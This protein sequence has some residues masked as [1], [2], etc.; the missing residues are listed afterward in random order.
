[1]LNTNWTQHRTDFQKFLPHLGRTF[2]WNALTSTTRSRRCYLWRYEMRQKRFV[3]TEAALQH[4]M[5]S[6]MKFKHGLVWD[7]LSNCNRALP[8]ASFRT[9]TDCCAV[10][11]H[12]GQHQAILAEVGKCQQFIPEWH[13]IEKRRTKMGHT[14]THSIYKTTVPL[15]CQRNFH[16]TKQKKGLMPFAGFLQRAANTAKTNDCW[17]VLSSSHLVL[18]NTPNP[19]S[20][21][22]HQT[23]MVSTCF[24]RTCLLPTKQINGQHVSL[25][26]TQRDSS[27]NRCK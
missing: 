4:N 1:M 15:V 10:G 11:D 26:K 19:D 6:L 5:N 27:A 23:R 25:E 13:H 3:H 7:S 22:W 12:I 8:L 9:C 16:V 24:G 21:Q 20:F 18:Q 14:D 2:H 17:V